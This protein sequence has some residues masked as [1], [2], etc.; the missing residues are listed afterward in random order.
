MRGHFL[1]QH[2][3]PELELKTQPVKAFVSIEN[4]KLASTQVLLFPIH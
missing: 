4:H 2:T 1:H 3:G